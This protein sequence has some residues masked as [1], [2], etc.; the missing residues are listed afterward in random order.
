MFNYLNPYDASK[1]YFASLKNNSLHLGVLEQ[2]MSWNFF[3]N[4]LL[5]KKS[6]EFF[7]KIYGCQPYIFPLQHTSS[8]LH[9]LQV[10]NCDSNSQLVG[11]EDYNEALKPHAKAS[12]FHYFFLNTIC[13]IRRKKYYWLYLAF[14][15][16]SLPVLI[17]SLIPWFIS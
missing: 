9:P 4:K 16:W 15:I 8:H 17:S 3:D 2:K 10:E 12:E 5:L 14:H 7:W 6:Y 13:T 11:G 1:H